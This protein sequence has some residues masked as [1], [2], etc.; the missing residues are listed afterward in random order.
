MARSRNKNFTKKVQKIVKKMAETKVKDYSFT[1]FPI[2]S[3][4]NYPLVQD[5]V[6]IPQ[7][8]ESDGRIGNQIFLSGIK[9]R[10]LFHNRNNPNATP[11]TLVKDIWVRMVILQQMNTTDLTVLDK[12]FRQ[13]STAIDFDT[14]TEQEKFF[15]PVDQ[16]IR[17]TLYQ[18]TFRLGSSNST[19]TQ[20]QLNN[21]ILKKY[22]SINKKIDFEN[23]NVSNS[24]A[25]KLYC[26]I[27]C[28]NNDLDAVLPNNAGYMEVSGLF[29]TY[30]KDF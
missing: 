26:I 12:F 27:W 29:S 20:N 17:K 10:L 4:M 8:G 3:D 22:R 9:W 28:G 1:E 23:S 2:R 13:G 18:T 25:N 15:L 5:L 24:A 11:S 19:Y 14:A 30:Y 6:Q 16:T 21:K 7:N